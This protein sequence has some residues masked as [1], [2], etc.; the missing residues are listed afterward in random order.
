MLL[1]FTNLFVFQI[2]YGTPIYLG[3]QIWN[4]GN[5]EN[6]QHDIVIYEKTIIYLIM[7]KLI[8]YAYIQINYK[9]L[10]E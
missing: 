4:K 1:E 6:E 9:T 2:V 5:Q 10:V 3:Q 8:S 7:Y